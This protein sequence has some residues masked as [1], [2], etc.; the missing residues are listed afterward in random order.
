MSN[1]D[2]PC[3][4][5]LCGKLQAAIDYCRDE[6]NITYA[7]VVGCLEIV[8]SDILDEIRDIESEGD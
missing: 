6:W 2:R 4:E 5:A 3:S 7:E 1:P 8:K